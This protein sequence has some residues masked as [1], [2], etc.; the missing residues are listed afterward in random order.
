M[1]RQLND[2]QIRRE[3]KELIASVSECRPEE[4][5][6]DVA[7]VEA[8]GIDSLMAMEILVG[9]EK[10]YRIVIPESEFTA[11]KTVNDAVAAAKRCLAQK[12]DSVA[13]ATD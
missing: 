7:F 1:N 2:E 6:D 4:I 5:G 12:P 9:V 10:K 3:V 8:L 13:G 11:I